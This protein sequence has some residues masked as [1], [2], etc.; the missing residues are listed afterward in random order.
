MSQPAHKI[1]DGVLQV[2]IWRNTSTSGQ[3]YYTATPQRSYRQGGHNL[4]GSMYPETAFKKV[5]RV[6]VPECRRC[7]TE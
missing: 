4:Q 7:S 1:R 5:Q 3:T 2:C 6:T